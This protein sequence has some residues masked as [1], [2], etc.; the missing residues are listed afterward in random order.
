MRRRGAG[1]GEWVTAPEPPPGIGRPGS[2]RFGIS[3]GSPGAGDP[4]SPA[5]PRSAGIRSQRDPLGAGSPGISPPRDPPG[6]GAREGGAGVWG[7]PGTHECAPWSGIAAGSRGI[8]SGRDK[9]A[10]WMHKEWIYPGVWDVGAATLELRCQQGVTSSPGSVE[11]PADAQP[12]G[13]GAGSS[14][15]G[16]SESAEELLAGSQCHLVGSA[17]DLTRETHGVGWRGPTTALP[18]GADPAPRTHR[19]PGDPGRIRCPGIPA[20][21]R[22]LSAGSAGIRGLAGGAAVTPGPCRPGG[23]AAGAGRGAGAVPGAALGRAVHPRAPA[24]VGTRA[25]P[26]PSHRHRP[27]G[28]S[29]DFCCGRTLAAAGHA[30]IRGREGLSRCGSS[31]DSQLGASPSDPFAKCFRVLLTSCGFFYSNFL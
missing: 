15:T 20:A 30:G 26:P 24:Q 12:V 22:R 21:R 23:R 2:R 9:L 19:G 13:D 6:A 25:R 28:G 31:G 29:R 17:W 1:N 14:I 18:G 3:Q 27:H 16:G 8:R 5:P 4:P 11:I 7:W 10:M